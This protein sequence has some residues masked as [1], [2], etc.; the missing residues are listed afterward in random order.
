MT[1]NTENFDNM[2]G[3]IIVDYNDTKLFENNIFNEVQTIEEDERVIDLN[4]SNNKNDDKPNEVSQLKLTDDESNHKYYN[5]NE[6]D[7]IREIN[8]DEE[9]EIRERQPNRKYKD[10]Y[11]H[12]ATEIN[13]EDKQ[14][15]KSEG[16]YILA[17]ILQEY[18][19]K[20]NKKR[21]HV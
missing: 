2:E 4:T 8:S 6:I 9:S 20:P 10:Y 11:Q 18:Q 15:Y 7:D 21:G 14:Q 12:F 19:N 13:E 1:N 17:H 3:E 16:A 5:K